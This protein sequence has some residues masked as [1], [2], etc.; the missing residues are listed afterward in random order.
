M[1]LTAV[2]LF[3][4]AGGM[5]LGLQNSGFDI[6][7]A[8]DNDPHCIHTYKANNPRILVTQAD[9]RKLRGKEILA[10][11]GRKSSEIDLLFGGPPC[12][13]FS[14]GNRHNGGSANPH[15]ELVF[16][17][18]RLVLEVRPKWFVM[19]NVMGLWNM[20]GG[21]I[22]DALIAELSGIYRVVAG[23]LNS[24]DYGVPQLRR[25]MFIVGTLDHDIPLKFPLAVHGEPTLEDLHRPPRVTV[26][27]AISDLPLLGSKLGKEEMAYTRK[28]RSAYQ[29]RMRRGS[30]RVLNHVV[31][32][33]S[34]DVIRRYR[35][36][37][38]GENWASLSD[39]AISEW[40]SSPVA[41]V[42]KVSHNN[43]YYRLDPRRP[44]PTIGNFRKCMII[45]PVEDR[46][47]SL[48]EAARLQSFPDRYAFQGGITSI[49]QQIGNATP[50]LLAE[51]IGRQIARAIQGRRKRE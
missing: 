18:S 43:L 30:P 26:E 36:I 15:N 49:Q 8:T 47:L 41:V 51:A 3:A 16:H 14:T 40:R 34:E 11:V 6:A 35:G 38:P 22:R 24:A 44:A 12:R 19:E 32:S 10:A 5:S 37:K 25:R 39:E 20:E 9:V 13:G 31:T 33:S 4:G 23:K 45:H 17:F 50:P 48:R 42:R 46:G 29:A 7:F 21:T 27:E 1:G 28:P 2:A